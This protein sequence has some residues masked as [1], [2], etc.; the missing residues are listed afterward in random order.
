MVT[1][2]RCQRPHTLSPAPGW[3]ANRNGAT[4]AWYGGRGRWY[5][6]GLSRELPGG[7]GVVCFILLHPR[8]IERDPDVER[9]AKLAEKW[10]FSELLIANLFARRVPIAAMLRNVDDPIG[11]DNDYAILNAAQAADLTVC[12][13]G[14]GGNYLDRGHIT[15]AALRAVG[16][17]PHALDV[18]LDRQPKL[19]RFLSASLRPFA[20]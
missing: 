19:P 12:A 17:A 3:F 13:W 20:I 2:Q 8:P 1:A 15:I 5:R 14:A 7:E 4:V 10:G 6:F 16:V 9:C 11:H 18:T